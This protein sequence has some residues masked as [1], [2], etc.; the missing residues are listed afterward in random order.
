MATN[1]LVDVSLRSATPADIP[2]VDAFIKPFVEDGKILDRT[3]AELEELIESFFIAERD[4]EIVG[5][6]VLEI[7]SRKLAEL[8]S[9]CVAPKMQGSGVGRLLVNACVARA[10]EKNI[11]EVMAITA[12]DPFFKACGFDY[13]MTGEKRAVFYQTKE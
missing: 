11:L 7:Y 1:P 8:R 2:A 12:N 5:C 4:G 3:P 10:R 6:V 13:T 9:L